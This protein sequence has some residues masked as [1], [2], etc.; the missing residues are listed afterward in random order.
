MNYPLS[1]FKINN[2]QIKTKN[3]N[4]YLIG[5][6]HQIPCGFVYQGTGV[7]NRVQEVGAKGTLDKPLKKYKTRGSVKKNENSFVKNVT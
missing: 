6:N 7:I 4:Q 1:H 2:V 3:K 5:I